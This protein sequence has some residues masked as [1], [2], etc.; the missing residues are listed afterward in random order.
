MKKTLS[1]LLALALLLAAFAPAA[2]AEETISDILIVYFTRVGISDFEPDVD[3]VTSASLNL[4]ENGELIG[5]CAIAANYIHEATGGDMFQIITEQRYPSAYR[6]TT[7]VAA[8]EQDENARPALASHVE[9]MDAY[10]TI[11]LAYPNWWGGLPMAVCAFLEEYD[12]SGKTIAPLCTHEGSGLGGT[13]RDIAGL[14]PES[15]LLDGLAIRGGR[16]SDAQ[17]AIGEWLAEIGI[18]SNMGM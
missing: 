6:A 3:A 11:I 16:V 14:C 9:N 4:D 17:E 2:C 13:P 12:L 8:V 1:M 10:S 7:D 15:T 18:E 5:N